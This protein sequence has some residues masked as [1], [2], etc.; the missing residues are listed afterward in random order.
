MSVTALADVDVGYGVKTL[1]LR[2]LYQIHGTASRVYD[3]DTGAGFYV[4]GENPRVSVPSVC[5]DIGI[6]KVWMWSQVQNDKFVIQTVL[7]SDKE[8]P[9]GTRWTPVHIFDVWT[10]DDSHYIDIVVSNS[11]VRMMLTRA[12]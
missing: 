2:G 3:F 6:T 9:D 12:K 8:P 10:V 5:A 11:I 4:D 1:V 7:G